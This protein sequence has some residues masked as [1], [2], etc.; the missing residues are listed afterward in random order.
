MDTGYRGIPIPTL[1][2][3]CPSAHLQDM[4]IATQEQ[5][6]RLFS[7]M[8]RLPLV[9]CHRDYWSENIFET[10]KGIVAIDWDCAGW[11]FAGED[12]ASLIADETEPALIGMYAQRLVPAYLRGLGETTGFSVGHTTADPGR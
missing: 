2:R 8:R 3:L 12:I 11:G 1:Q 7:E 10:R 5:A 4:L 9:L 6:S